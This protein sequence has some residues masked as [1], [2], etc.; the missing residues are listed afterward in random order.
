MYQRAL[1]DEETMTCKCG[2]SRGFHFLGNRSSSCAMPSCA[3]MAYS[4]RKAAVV[5]RS[6]NHKKW[7]CAR[8]FIFLLAL[9]END[10]PMTDGERAWL[11]AEKKVRPNEPAETAAVLPQVLKED[12]ARKA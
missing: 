3:C 6:E 8:L 2:H 12:K 7:A 5:E 10:Q 4:E 9:E 1:V 11:N